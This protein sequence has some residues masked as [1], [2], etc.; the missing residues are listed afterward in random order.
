LRSLVRL[1]FFRSC[2]AAAI[3]FLAA[4]LSARAA[5][6]QGRAL[7]VCAQAGELDAPPAPAVSQRAQRPLKLVVVL[8]TASPAPPPARPLALLDDQI[9]SPP[10]GAHLPPPSTRG[11]PRL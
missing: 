5:E 8:A 9:E 11:P 10:P 2:F 3:L 7:Q 6:P 1:R 4:C